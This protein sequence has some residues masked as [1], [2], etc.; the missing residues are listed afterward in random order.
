MKQK[1]IAVI[2]QKGGVGKTT[3]TY[4]IGAAIADNGYN[5]LLID[6]DPQGNLSDYLGYAYDD[7]KPMIDTLMNMAVT[8]RQV[9]SDVV[10][11]CDSAN[12]DYIPA[13]INLSI[14]ERFLMQAV[15]R[16]TVLRRLLQN[17]IFAQYDYILIDCLPS[18]GLLAMNAITAATDLLIPVQ[19]QKFALD[20]VD[21]LLSVVDE[22]RGPLNPDL[23]ILGILPTM[24]DRTNMSYNVV[25]ALK[26][27]YGDKVLNAYVSKSVLAA[28]S[29]Y[30]HE[31][32]SAKSKL[33]I[34][35]KDIADELINRMR[36]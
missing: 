26:Q 23:N 8:N 11:H 16:E 5:V 20:G 25:E 22:I 15:S 19:S 24:V 18:L 17:D 4:N 13:D 12:V 6:L 9:V 36:G 34:Q 31:P 2:N 32:I 27:K 30:E 33:G 3:S 14:A 35:Y 29:A 1:V 28:D 10:R 21:L 7:N